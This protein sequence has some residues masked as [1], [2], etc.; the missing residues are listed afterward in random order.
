M[1]EDQI[2]D[3]AEQAIF[4]Q[5]ADSNWYRIL[6]CDMGE[7]YFQGQDEDTGEEYRFNFADIK[8]GS[9][10]GFHKLVRMDSVDEAA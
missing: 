4:Y 9:V 8:L 3:L 5:D 10:E 7:G 6:Y 2:A 1:T